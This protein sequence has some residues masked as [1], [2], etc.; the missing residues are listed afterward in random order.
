MSDTVKFLIPS[1]P[2][3]T[4]SMT[5]CDAIENVIPAGAV[6]ETSGKMQF[7][8]AGENFERVRCPFCHADLM[9]WWNE[10]ID[11]AYSEDAGFTKLA[12]IM[13]CCGNESS[14]N[15]LEYFWAQGFYSA[16]ISFCF[17]DIEDE[18][19][20]LEKMKAVTGISW[21]VITARY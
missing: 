13:P 16:K 18:R 9:E 20:L 6:L 11:A 8:D 19:D 4:P 10:A 2:F 7:A 5:Q 14:L 21:R 17:D 1:D 3:Y 12:V 15:D